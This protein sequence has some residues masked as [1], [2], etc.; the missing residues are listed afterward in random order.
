ME[1][2]LKLKSGVVLK[3]KP[4]A[5][6]AIWDA[7]AKIEMPKV[8]VEFI[9]SKGRTEEN[10]MHPDYIAAMEKY[11]GDRTTAAQDVM[12][13]MGTELMEVPE[14]FQRPE[15]EWWSEKVEFLGIEVSDKKARRYLQWLRYWAITDIEDISNFNIEMARVSGTSEEDVAK[16][17]ESFRSDQKRAVDMARKRTTSRRDRNRV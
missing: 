8:P 15:D 13:A 16:M 11:D 10:P 12:W 3:L 5:L 9:E 17:A 7:M 2:L 4:V 6:Q 1:N 14:G